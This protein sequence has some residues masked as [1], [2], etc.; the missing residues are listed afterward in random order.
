MLNAVEV[1]PSVFC[2]LYRLVIIEVTLA[3]AVLMYFLI[4]RTRLGMLIRAGASNREMV[5]ALGVNIKLLYTMVFA[6]FTFSLPIPARAGRGAI[7][8]DPREPPTSF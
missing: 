1:L 4:M 2:P 5:G 3:V 6:P 7:E 8:T